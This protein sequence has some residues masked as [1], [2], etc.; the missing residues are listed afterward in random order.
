[1]TAAIVMAVV[2]KPEVAMPLWKLLPL[3]QKRELAL[4]HFVGRRQITEQGND[5]VSPAS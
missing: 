3:L 4:S 5:S 2:T 1:M